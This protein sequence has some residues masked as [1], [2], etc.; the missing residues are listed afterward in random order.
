MG[1]GIAKQV[2]DRFPGVDKAAGQRVNLTCG[3]LGFYGLLGDPA[4]RL[5]LFQVKRNFKADAELSLIEQSTLPQIL[6]EC[7]DRLINLFAFVWQVLKHTPVMIPPLVEELD[8]SDS[9]F[10]E[11]PRQEAVVGETC[12]ARL[13][14]IQIVSLL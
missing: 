1:R 7:S 10:D 2:R 11:S 5:M 8:E 13:R 12:G 14:A 6:D 3:H 4:K 9:P